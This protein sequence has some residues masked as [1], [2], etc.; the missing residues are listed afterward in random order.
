MEIHTKSLKIIIK[1]NTRLPRGSPHRTYWMKT[2]VNGRCVAFSFNGFGRE[3][4][5]DG[6]AA[7]LRSNALTRP[8]VSHVTFINIYHIYFGDWEGGIGQKKGDQLPLFNM[9]STAFCALAEASMINFL[10][11]RSC[12][13]QPWMYAV[14]S[15]SVSSFR[16]PAWLLRNAAPIPIK[17]DPNIFSGWRFYGEKT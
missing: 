7:V 8:L 15:C 17:Y 13:S 5:T 4:E 9:L 3:C 12:F 14:E 10:S 11:L 2:I 1:A 6:I 16:M